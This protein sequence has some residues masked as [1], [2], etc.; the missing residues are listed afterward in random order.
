MQ[1]EATYPRVSGEPKLALMRERKIGHNAGQ[2]AK[3][4]QIWK[5]LG[6]MNV[7]EQHCIE[8]QRANKNYKNVR[9]FLLLLFFRIKSTHT[10]QIKKIPL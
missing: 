5:E 1:W 8:S 3:G 7:I 4:R 6:G 9:F 2:E 10:T